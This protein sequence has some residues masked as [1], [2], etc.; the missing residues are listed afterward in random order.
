[1]S[2]LI[3]NEQ[4]INCLNNIN[5]VCKFIDDKETIENLINIEKNLYKTPFKIYCGA[6]SK[7]SYNEDNGYF[8]ELTS[9]Q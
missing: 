4:C 3:P 8:G 1:M 5:N 6:F 2:K 9:S 7:K